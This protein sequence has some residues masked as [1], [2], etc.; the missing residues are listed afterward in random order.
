M[1]E[2]FSLV[3]TLILLEKLLNHA[4]SKVGTMRAFLPRL[5]LLCRRLTC[6]PLL[7]SLPARIANFYNLTTATNY[8]ETLFPTTVA[9]GLPLH[10]LLHICHYI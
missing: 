2:A 1:K 5:L 3:S 6:D 4:I 7:H 8:T 9:P 10:Q